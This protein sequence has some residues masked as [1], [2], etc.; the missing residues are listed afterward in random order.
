MPLRGRG[1]GT[2][3]I[4]RRITFRP[5]RGDGVPEDLPAVLHGAVG[6]FH[7]ASALNP[8]QHQE[9]FRCADVGDRAPAKPGKQVVLESAQDAIAVAWDPPRRELRVPLPSDGLEAVCTRD[10]QLLRLAGLPWIDAGG[11]LLSDRVTSRT[12]RLQTDVRVDAEGQPLFLAAEAVFPAPPL[13]AGGADLH[14]ETSTVEQLARPSLR[15]GCADRGVR[16]WHEGATH[17]RCLPVAP[18]V[19][20]HVGAASPGSDGTLPDSISG[21]SPILSVCYRPYLNLVARD[22]GG[23]GGVEP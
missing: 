5:A 4:A 8:A 17:V 14:V 18:R 6:R 19:A 23:G 10:S 20:P 7:G 13:A 16:Q 3:N 9:Q 2:P 15:F 22:V 21:S 11:K 12:G 1:E